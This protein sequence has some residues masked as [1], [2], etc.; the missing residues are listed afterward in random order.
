[1]ARGHLPAKFQGTIL[2]TD[3]YRPAYLELRIE[4]VGIFAVADLNSETLEALLNDPNIRHV[5]LAEAS[6]HRR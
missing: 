4:L 5:T 2:K 1:M 6:Q 3:G